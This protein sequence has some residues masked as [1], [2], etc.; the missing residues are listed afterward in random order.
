MP[1]VPMSPLQHA[2]RP[3]QSNLIL[4]G[5]PGS[6]KSTVGVLL[7]KALRMHFV[8][9]DV[10]IQAGEGRSLREIIDQ[11]GLDGFCQIERDYLLC[12]DSRNSVIAT[13]GSAI[14]SEAAMRHLKATGPVIFLDAPLEELQRRLGDWH[15]RGVILPQ[16]HD[17]ATLFHDRRPLYERFADFI[18][19]CGGKAHERVMEEILGQASLSVR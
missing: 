4:I 18:I 11:R 17:L 13:G 9:T 12:L 19:L 5:M 3:G 2:Y 16:G 10:C 8:D 6:G 7:A 1:L 15:D 14:Y